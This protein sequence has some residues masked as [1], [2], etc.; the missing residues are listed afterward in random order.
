MKTALL[1]N[2]TF[3]KAAKTVQFNDFLTVDKSRIV[4]VIDTTNGRQIFS[5]KL[6]THGGTVATNVLTLTYDTNQDIFN[7]ADVLIAEYL[8]ENIGDTV[9]AS[10]MRN[11]SSQ[12]SEIKNLGAKG[13]VFIVDT[14]VV[15]GTDPELTVKIQVKDVVSGAWVDL[16]GAVT[17]T[18]NATGQ[19][20]LTVYPGIAE[21]ANS[22][23]S[24]VLPRSYRAAWTIGGTDPEF[25]FS[26]GAN[27]IY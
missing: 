11:V 17:A 22:K 18:I 6:S 15:D 3:D 12:T 23:V 26:I 21:A 25:T 2:L 9:A 4:S 5:N 16:P 7:D 27:Y 1:T 20:M 8:V 14:T 24:H 13:A 10:A 19:T